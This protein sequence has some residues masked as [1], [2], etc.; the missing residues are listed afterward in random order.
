M[1]ATDREWLQVHDFGTEQFLVHGATGDC[2]PIYGAGVDNDFGGPWEMLFDENGRGCLAGL[3]GDDLTRSLKDPG[4][5]LPH[6]L[7]VRRRP[8]SENEE[9][10]VRSRK[11]SGGAG[12]WLQDLISQVQPAVFAHGDFKGEV[13]IHRIPKVVPAAAEG[14]ATLFVH[15]WFALP[16]VV[17]YLFR[18]AVYPENYIGKSRQAWRKVLRGLGLA[19][20]HIRDSAKSRRAQETRGQT[21]GASSANLLSSEVEFSISYAG[22]VALLLHWHMKT[23]VQQHG[24]K[25]RFVEE[26]PDASRAF[27]LMKALFGML[28][29]GKCLAFQLTNLVVLL[30]NGKV[31]VEELLSSQARCGF[32]KQQRLGK[33]FAQN[34]SLSDFLVYLVNEASGVAMSSSNICHLGVWVPTLSFV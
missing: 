13:Y 27:S 4:E 26:D 31:D 7:S 28:L 14:S 21:T 20:E 12:D 34:I 24:R 16:W 2:V 11:N 17:S 15:I 30:E 22:L 18:S 1:S 33:G 8:A 29:A 32:A 3:D 9:F 25:R 19:Q 5:V 10:F 23:H 6:V